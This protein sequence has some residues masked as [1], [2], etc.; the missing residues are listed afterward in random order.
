MNVLK[1]EL[2]TGLKPFIFWSIGLFFLVFAGVVKFTGI[3]GVEGASVKELFDKFPKIILALF[4]MAG[5]DATSIDGYYGILA[6]YA[7]ICGMIYGISLGTNIIN[8]EVVDKT[9]EFIF[10]KP[11][12]RSYIVN[13]KFISAIIYLATFSLLNYIFSIVAIRTLDLKENIDKEILLFSL[14][15]FIISMLYCVI[16][17]F[18]A[19]VIK[20]YEKGNLYGNLFFFVTFILS[21]IYDV[22]ENG[23][24]IRIF[25]PFKYLLPTDIVNGKFEILPL[26]A[27]IVIIVAL[28][29]VS[30]K[31]FER[32]EFSN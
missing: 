2:K 16:G 17:I 27:S 5:L 3:S 26:I 10:T 28:Y 18:I 13:M 1:K 9:F 11:R 21:I 12:K 29:I 23:S 8:R 32:K 7:L 20:N 14:A 31:I 24:I 15:I 19:T 30:L 4:G 22:V 6:F 25:T